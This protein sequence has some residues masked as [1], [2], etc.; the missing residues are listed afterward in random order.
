MARTQSYKALTTYYELGKHLATVLH[1]TEQGKAAHLSLIVS[2]MSKSQRMV[3][4]AVYG[5][6]V[7][8]K[9]LTP[10]KDLDEEAKQE[11]KA[12][13]LEFTAGKNLTIEQK[14]EVAK[15][16]YALEFILNELCT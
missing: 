11:L 6:C 2:D 14:V 7:T 5:E 3:W 8:L 9:G 15:C 12:S 4:L 1:Q 16:L 13:T 10:I